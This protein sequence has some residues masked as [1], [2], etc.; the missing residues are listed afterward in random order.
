MTMMDLGAAAPSVSITVLGMPLMPLAEQHLV[1]TVVDTSLH[2]L[3]MFELTFHDHDQKVLSLTGIDIG[4]EIKIT[5]GSMPMKTDLIVG[6]VTSIEGDY[7]NALHLTIVRG[8]EHAHRLQKARRSRTFI[9]MSDGDIATKVARDAKLK[10]GD[11][12]DPGVTHPYLAQVAQTDWEFLRGRAQEIG[13]DVGVVDGKFTFKPAPGMPAGGLAGA[14]SAAASA[15][16]SLLGMNK[17]TFG[18][19]LTWIRPRV[20]SGG[21]VPETEVRVWDPSSVAVV[22][23]KQGIKSKTASIKDTPP[24]LASAHGGLIPGLPAISIPGLPSFGA[25]SNN[26]YLIAGR[27]LAQ[28][29]S[30]QSAAD[31]VAKG[32]AEHAASTFAEAEGVAVASPWLKAGEKVTL[33]NLT[34]R[35]DGD[36]YVTAARHE[37]DEQDGFQTRFEI[38]GRHDRSLHGLVTGN[39]SDRR[40][41]GLI[42][43][44]VPGIV[45]NNSDDEKMRRVKVS[46]PWL[47]PDFET[48]WARVVMPG[49]GVN[50]GFVAIPEVGDEVL[51]GFELG[52]PRRAYV[53]GGLWNGD[54]KLELGGDPVKK[55]ALG[56]MVVKRGLVSRLGHK[57]LVDDDGDGKV[58]PSKS[59][60]TIGTKDDKIMIKYD[61]VNKKI[62]ILCDSSS[63]PAAIEI[64]QNGAG[65]SI[66]IEQAG[67]NGTLTLKSG[68]NV[69]VEAGPSGKLTLKGGAS[70]VA[71]EGGAGM[72]EIKGSQVK[73][74]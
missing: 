32:I 63:P 49:L 7:D 23:S 46:L 3:D 56:G 62:T 57:I 13:Y 36:W 53:L 8:Y 20:T 16:G 44:L 59:G 60:V 47:A 1:R 29:S 17:L 27:P 54:T 12:Q 67:S 72:V 68:G 11:V 43:G 74:N 48:D 42:D 66:T 21:L 50:Y 69:N 26:A 25:V 34:D 65:G 24:K 18:E 31:A 30:A 73:L 4:S 55:G 2:R 22:S 28:G 6:E 71:I 41:R 38:S 15:A 61:E 9:D 19:N 70:G 14:A 33:D 37:F 35:F 40:A 45:T 10:I 5:T 64:K 51:V 58:P 39:Q 52:D